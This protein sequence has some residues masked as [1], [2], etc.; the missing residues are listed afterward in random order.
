MD[1]CAFDFK[2]FV[3]NGV[4]IFS[5]SRS[6]PCRDKQA[7]QSD[8]R[9]IDTASRRHPLPLLDHDQ[10]TAQGFLDPMHRANLLRGSIL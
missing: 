3:S 5:L 8:V 4:F 10:V 9:T 6:D 7:P 1:S 2:L